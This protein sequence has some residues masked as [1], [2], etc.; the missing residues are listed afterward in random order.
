MASEKKSKKPRKNNYEEKVQTD[1]SFE[2][3]MTVLFPK[4]G[5]PAPMPKTTTPAKA[6]KKK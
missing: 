2:E 4:Q 1:A 3:L 5:A 6:K